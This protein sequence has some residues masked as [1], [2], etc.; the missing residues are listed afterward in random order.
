MP[1]TRDPGKVTKLLQFL[2][3]HKKPPQVDPRIAQLGDVLNQVQDAC[4][5]IPNINPKKREVPSAITRLRNMG[6]T[7]LDKAIELAQGLLEFCQEAAP[8]PAPSD[9]VAP[10]PLDAQGSE[11]TTSPTSSDQ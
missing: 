1:A 2:G 7:D 10:P 5:R 11:A 9:L 4:E 8:P 3:I 6:R